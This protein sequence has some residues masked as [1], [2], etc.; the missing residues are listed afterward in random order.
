[1]YP[2]WSFS[3]HESFFIYYFFPKASRTRFELELGCFFSYSAWADERLLGCSLH[4]VLTFSCWLLLSI[5]PI[6][7]LDSIMNVK[8]QWNPFRRSRYHS[9]V[10]LESQKGHSTRNIVFPRL[11]HRGICAMLT[12]HQ[13]RNLPCGMTKPTSAESETMW[14]KWSQTRHSLPKKAMTTRS[15]NLDP[16]PENVQCWL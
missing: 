13:H 8:V 5:R 14:S 12:T 1:M 4:H 3:Y 2:G 15:F 10:I 11:S 7:L 6:F 9:C 16:W